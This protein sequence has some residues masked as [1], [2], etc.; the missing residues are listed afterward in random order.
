[1]WRG[2][3]DRLG[4]AAGFVGLLSL[5]WY[6]VNRVP[7]GARSVW[8]DWASTDIANL[9]DHPAAAL[10]ASAFVGASGIAQWLALALVG[11]GATGW[12]LG[13]WRTALLVLAGHAVG[14]YLSEGILAY[15]IAAHLAPPSQLRVLD[16]GPSYVVIAGLAAGV[17]YGRWAGRVPAAI[18]LASMAPGSFAGL[19]RWDV[20]AL[21]HVSSVLVAVTLGWW[22]AR[23][24]EA[25]D[26]QEAKCACGRQVA[27]YVPTARSRLLSV[28]YG[29]T[30]Q[31]V[32]R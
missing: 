19:S 24:R 31:T 28:P 16:I 12:V 22:L 17:A 10:V 1:V 9:A 25:A 18:G 11:L 6:G 5:S 15:R 2:W 20:A 13:A 26:R 7:P 21:G 8:L 4:V 27:K 29:C 14:T 23:D 32:C 3:G 30:P